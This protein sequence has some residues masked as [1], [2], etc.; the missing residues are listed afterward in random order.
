MRAGEIS[1][2]TLKRSDFRALDFPGMATAAPAGAK[3]AR[4]S[5]YNLLAK[6]MDKTE[7]LGQVRSS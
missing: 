5:V 2:N 1:A 3:A 4:G 7:I 6:V